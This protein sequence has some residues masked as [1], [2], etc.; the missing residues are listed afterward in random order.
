MLS[1]KILATNSSSLGSYSFDKLVDY[2]HAWSY[3]LFQ[4]VLKRPT[5]LLKIV[6]VTNH[7][8]L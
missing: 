2:R 4:I 1:K 5:K 8:R 3:M 7:L 6:T